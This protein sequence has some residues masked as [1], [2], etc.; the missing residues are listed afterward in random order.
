MSRPVN[1]RAEDLHPV[2]RSEGMSFAINGMTVHAI[3]GE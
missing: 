2:F 3:P 1:P